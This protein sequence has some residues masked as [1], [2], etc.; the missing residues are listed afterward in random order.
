[1]AIAPYEFQCLIPGE[2]L[3]STGATTTE[4]LAN[5]FRF[6]G[7]KQWFDFYNC[8]VTLPEEGRYFYCMP[9]FLS[10]EEVDA[11]RAGLTL[12][13]GGNGGPSG[14][15]VCDDRFVGREGW[16]ASTEGC[17]VQWTLDGDSYHFTERHIR[18]RGPTTTW[19]L[20]IEPFLTD[21][22]EPL[23]D[24]R[25][26]KL[27]E[28]TFLRQVP[29]IH[30]VP[31]MKAWGR[32]VI[33][34]QGERYEF[35]RAIV[36]QA[37]NHGHNYPK[38]WTWVFGAIF[39]EDPNLAFET[40]GLT[41]PNGDACMMRISTPDGVR[42]LSNW[43]GDEVSVRRQGD[44]Y[45]FTGIAGDGSLEVTG[46]A[47]HGENVLFYFPSPDGRTLE[48]DESF[49]GSLTVTIDGKKYHGRFPALGYLRTVEG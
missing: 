5:A 25:M 4:P 22:E 14:D 40:A 35:D 1:M 48:N 46:E 23:L 33:E 13:D 7:Q 2:I 31:R 41:G 26:F 21:R 49:V 18:F 37:K 11:S 32:G 3:M 34:Q 44:T 42:M 19:D 45:R 17:D 24:P 10:G 36:Y 30:R 6:T 28:R 12:Y 39:D 16:S 9:Y 8:R 29:F 38:D 20:E 47:E 43:G 15:S 27:E